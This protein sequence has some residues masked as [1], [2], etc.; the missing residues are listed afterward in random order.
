[1][2]DSHR[3]VLLRKKGN[4]EEKNTSAKPVFKYMGTF[5]IEVANRREKATDL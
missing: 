3:I 2:L 5:R 4:T 1:M